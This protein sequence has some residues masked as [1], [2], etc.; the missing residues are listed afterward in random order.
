MKNLILAAVPLLFVACAHTNAKTKT[1]SMSP[2]KRSIAEDQY[3]LSELEFLARR[4]VPQR[5]IIYHVQAHGI[6]YQQAD[7]KLTDACNKLAVERARG[8]DPHGIVALISRYDR[9]PNNPSVAANKRYE[10]TAMC[11]IYREG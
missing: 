3:G 7:D 10:L 1:S 5:H 11:S 9:Q 8:K 4:R 2:V 6:S